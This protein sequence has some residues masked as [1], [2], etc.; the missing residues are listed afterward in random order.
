K[1]Y[2]SK[3]E[4]LDDIV[5]LL[6]GR[7]AEALVLGD[8]STGASNDIKRATDIARNM[9]TRYGMS[10]KLG[11]IT[12]GDDNDEVFLGMQYSHVRNYSEEIAAEIDKEVNRIITEQY[13]R[14][15][16]ILTEHM[17]SLH[18]V[19]NA[20]LEKEK[21][22]G[23]EF[24]VLLETGSLPGEADEAAEK[25]ETQ[26]SE[27][28]E[29]AQPARAETAQTEQPSAPEMQQEDSDKSEQ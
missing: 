26:A 28:V 9:I 27:S 7:V 6:G 23:D 15:E 29:A 18:L 13:A 3:N 25:T 14:T 19:A 5:V 16:Q 11:P 12:F 22:E 17:D 8:I 20:L 2:Q 10:E 24:K 21:L 4:M 1:S